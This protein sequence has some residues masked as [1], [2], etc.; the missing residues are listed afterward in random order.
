MNNKKVFKQKINIRY[1]QVELDHTTL[2]GT[3][4]GGNGKFLGGGLFS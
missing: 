3:P 2:L 1:L 4:F